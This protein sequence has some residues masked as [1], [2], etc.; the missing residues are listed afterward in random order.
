MVTTRKSSILGPDG[1]PVEVAILSEEMA[2][3]GLWGVRQVPRESV[4][5][6]MSPER[7]GDVL[8]AATNGHPRAYLTLAIDMEERYLHYSSQLQTRRLAFDAI[9][10]SVSSP[11][12][13]PPKITHAVHELVEAPE[14][15]DACADLT[16]GISKGFA[17]CE[18]MWEFES[19]LLR[20]V[21]YAFRDPRYFT[22]DRITLSD[23]RLIVDHDLEGTPLPDAKFLRHVPRTRSGL[24]L[25]T[26]LARPAAWA[27]LIQNFTL[28][29][30]AAF[31]EI[32]G[33]PFRVG[34]YHQSA[35][36][37]D[38]RTL[39][40]AVRDIA[41]DAGAII[42]IGMDIEFHEV[43]GQQGER[44]FGGLLG[45]LDR[46]ISKLVVGQTMTADDGSSL[47]QAKIHNE[48]RLDI[49]R[50]DCRQMAATIN[51]QLVE[52]FVSMNFGPQERYPQVEFQVTEPEDIKA[53]SEATDRM[54]RLGLKVSQ[55][56][57]RK[58]IGLSEPVEGEDILVAMPSAAPVASQE[59]NEEPKPRRKD[60]LSALSSHGTGCRCASC[61]TVQLA[62]DDPE[63]DDLDEVMADALSDW[64]EI[65]DPLLEQL[66]ALA[67][68]CGSFEE[69][70]VK[71][72]ALR[73]DTGPLQER[74]ARACAISR[75]IGDVKDI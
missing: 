19:G 64:Q 37:E 17:V 57:M 74:L 14:F 67:A 44:V 43:S 53:V 32:Y 11:D 16:D 3:P 45:Y 72:D 40:R 8:R 9:P 22:V 54:V 20:P 38:K 58:K 52:Y 13:V 7:L 69:V 62:A 65:T 42:P 4:A 73:L 47:G 63:S 59:R 18:M 25:R 61:R 55:R 6:G 5:T 66:F 21:S 30:W 36:M 1:A 49:L 41:N 26:G 48:V 31:C 24:P 39:L 23:L 2:A 15:R 27:F 12:G 51:R 70:L 10:A 50:A 33:V 56:E 34:K 29:D 35:S 46:Q 68:N 75:G 60:R 71:L 28:Q